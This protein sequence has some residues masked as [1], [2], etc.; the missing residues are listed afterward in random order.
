VDHALERQ[1]PGARGDRGAGG[2]GAARLD[3]P[4]ALGLQRR[5]GCA[6]DRRRDAAA[7]GE[8]PVGRI[9][10]GVDRLGEQVPADQLEEA[11]G[12]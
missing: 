9:D 10:D 4:V 6:R 1:P 12:R 3:Q 7:V 5:P 11:P 2:Q 8:A